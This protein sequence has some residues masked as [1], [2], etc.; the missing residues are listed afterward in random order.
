MTLCLK[1]NEEDSF[2]NSHQLQERIRHHGKDYTEA[3]LY[4]PHK[5][6]H[7]L[8]PCRHRLSMACKMM[9]TTESADGL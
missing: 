7:L 2:A 3:D 6:S 8:E 5:T 4:G 9:S 1:T